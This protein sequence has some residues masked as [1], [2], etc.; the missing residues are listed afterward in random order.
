MSTLLVGGLGD[1][2]DRLLAAAL[3]TAGGRRTA[4]LGALDADAL[5]RGRSA[6]PR[7]QCA[8]LLYTTGALLRAAEEHRGRP[9]EYLTVG[10]CGPC[11]FALFETAWR[12][13]L[14]ERGHSGVGFL[15]AD[16]NTESLAGAL[17]SMRVVVRAIEAL[18]VA[19]V[20]AEMAHRLRPR[21]CDPDALDARA[22][23]AAFLVARDVA[24]GDR[25]IRALA[26][27]HD[28]HRGLALRPL[29]PLGR[30]VLIGEPWSLHTNGEGRLHLPRVLARAG[31]ETEVPPATLWIRYLLWQVRVAPWG[32]G[33][34]P[35]PAAVAFAEA[36]EARLLA[37]VDE[38]AKVAGLGGFAIPDPEELSRHAAPWFPARLRGGYGHIEVGL[39]A[40]ARAERRAHLVLSVKSFG[41]VPS[42]GVADGIVPAVLGDR[43]PFLAV[44]VCGDGDAAR[45][46]RLMLRVADAIDAAEVDVDAAL[47]AAG[48]GRDADMASFA[49]APLAGAHDLGTRAYRCTLACDVVRA[50]VHRAVPRAAVESR[51]PCA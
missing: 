25:P 33:P 8:P 19:D 13:A 24:E 23:Q 22:E 51:R 7:G 45:E 28:F 50:G 46:S 12:R 14:E 6:L 49:S 21:V 26:R 16:Q 2:H 44:E 40:R 38:A 11:R 48:L 5:E 47:H 10:S 43:V 15:S 29:A 30:A 17:G 1:P 27:H 18:V 41:C 39:A 32:S 9:F 34:M 35:A 42:A 36:L 20:L 31:V 3:A 4:L 37:A